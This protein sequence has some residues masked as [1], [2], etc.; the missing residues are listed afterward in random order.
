MVSKLL[1]RILTVIPAVLVQL[2]W[3]GLL[4]KW[5]APYAL[6]L[7]YI[8]SVLSFFFVL[9]IITKRD[10]G[11]YKI[12]WLLVIL[13]APIPGALLYAL[14]GNK[15]TAGPLR[16]RLEKA[17]QALPPMG[18]SGEALSALEEEEPR[19]AQTFRWMAGTTGY[20]IRVNTGA[21]YYPIGEKLYAAMLQ[22]L[23]KAETFIFAEYFI[24]A[25]GKMWDTMVD[26]MARKVTEGVD[27]RVMYDDLGSIST[28]SK[29]NVRELEAKG[30]RC[31]PVNRMRAIRGVLNY[32]DH[33]K[34]LVIDGKVAFS[35]GVNLSG[36]YINLEVKFGHWKDVGFKLTGPG[37]ESYTRMY[38]LFWN[39]FGGQPI[40]ETLLTPPAFTAEVPA[41]G[42]VLS[43]YDSP[44]TNQAESNELYIELLS[45]ARD[46][47]W[48]FTPYLMPGDALI[49]AFV[50]AARRGVDIRI[51]MP[52]IPDKKMIFRMSHSFYP[53]LLEAGVKIYEYIPG[54]V[55]AKGCLMDDKV[56]AVGTVNLD[57]RSLFLH[58][59]N[60]SLFYGASLLQDMK[61][62]F[63]D[64][65]EK[66][67]EMVLGE[68]VKVGFWHWT[69]DGIL[70]I[71][72]PL[73]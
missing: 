45:Q 69:V 34:M 27:V 50:R 26:I 40:P 30:I 60:N 11:T 44:F 47:I 3:L 41:D 62:D 25:R 65:Q 68:N 51:I 46:Y 56:C 55:H 35:G 38:T 2:F 37:V 57:Y 9:Y 64:T 12:L 29:K 28:Y 15:R 63:L 61:A 71:F 4:S 48:F 59:E 39:T 21:T 36:E 58:F 54:F 10:E 8:L 22:E 14:F 6:V 5:L 49:D 43:Y 52:G 18:D 42:C 66:S 20:P 1:G 23:E 32:R 73:C 72:A 24:I 70:R 19:L 17:E 7:N 16:H 31:I 33:R 13:I 67:R 53:V